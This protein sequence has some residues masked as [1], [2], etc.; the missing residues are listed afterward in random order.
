MDPAQSRPSRG[1]ACQAY[2]Q[3]A[4]FEFYLISHCLPSGMVSFYFIGTDPLA[5]A[6][7]IAAILGPAWAFSQ[8]S[9]GL[10]AGRTRLPAYISGLWPARIS[11]MRTQWMAAPAFT[12]S[13]DSHMLTT[14][15]CARRRL[16]QTSS[17]PVA[18]IGVT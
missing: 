10:Q 7:A 9:C 1:R 16:T 2:Q 18:S 13:A 3:D 11:A 4:K 8:I 17:L 12:L 15:P 14:L 6:W 5:R